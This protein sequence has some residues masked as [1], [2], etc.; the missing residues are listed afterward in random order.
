MRPRSFLS[1]CL[2]FL[3]TAIVSAAPV[4][5]G[6]ANAASNI[7][8]NSP[9]ALGSIFVITGTGLGPANI[10]ISPTPFKTTTL[11]GTSIAVNVN[12]TTVNALMYYTSATQVAA[13]LPS[14]TPLPPAGGAAPSFTVTYNGQ[15]SPGANHGVTS[16]NVGIFTVDSSGQGPGIVTFADYSLVSAGKANP[17]GGPNTA[18]GAANP[19]DTLILW[20]T[21]IGPVN[22]DDASGAGLGQNMANVPLTVWLGGVQAKVAYQGRS[23]CCIGED[24]IVFTVPDNAPTGCAVPLVV[25][26]GTVSNTISNTTTM[27]V[28]KGS[29]DCAPANPA[30]SSSNIGQT[31]IAGPLSFGSIEIHKRLNAGN[32]TFEEKATAIFARATSYKPGLQPFFLSYLDDIPL[33]TCAVFG[34]LNGPSDPPIAGL[35]PLDAGQAVTIKG[36]NGSANVPNNGDDAPLSANGNFVVPGAFT[37]TGTGGKDV[38]AFTATLTIPPSPTLLSPAPGPNLVITRSNGQAITWNANGSTGS[39]D[40]LLLSAID[41]QFTIG[42]ALFCR[43][44]ASAGSFAIPPYALLAL[45]AGTL[46]LLQIGSGLAPFPTANATFTANGLDVGL[47]QAFVDGPA[48]GGFQIR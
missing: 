16:S 4:I 40:I 13:L 27:P 44:P 17:C 21:G 24:Q 20:A 2:F 18:C 3:T 48:I 9:I 26:I 45:P 38:G 25:Q 31:V 41:N 33:N 39:V 5:T 10:S 7:P 8:F 35:A 22:G 42:A 29:R 36:P 28:A 19:G 34:N 15:T 23:G 32:Q 30:L 43:A 11:S 14:N 47:V 12:G 1:C 46:T 37:V 6:I